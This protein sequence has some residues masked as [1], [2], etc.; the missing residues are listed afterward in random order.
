MKKRASDNLPTIHLQTPHIDFN[1][2]ELYSPAILSKYAPQNLIRNFVIQI[3]LEVVKHYFSGRQVQRLEFVE[4]LLKC[5]SVNKRELLHAVW[6]LSWLH[7]NINTDFNRQGLVSFTDLLSYMIK[8][9]NGLGNY[10]S[11]IK[12]FV[13]KESETDGHAEQVRVYE[14]HQQLQYVNLNTENF[15]T[16]G[17]SFGAV[18]KNCVFEPSIARFIVSTEG[19]NRVYLFNEYCELKGYVVPE[20]IKNNENVPIQ[21]LAFSP[22]DK[23]V[24]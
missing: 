13:T 11:K 19:S 24:I 4:I 23:R 12:E 8:E 5:L 2:P 22:V 15:F 14:K 6:G 7:E 10:G 1:R 18:V 16:N 9:Y 20:K 21:S 17:K 3:D